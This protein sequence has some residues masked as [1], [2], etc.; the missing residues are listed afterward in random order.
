M[1]APLFFFRTASIGL[2][3][4]FF[5]KLCVAMFFKFLRL[6]DLSGILRNIIQRYFVD[7]CHFGQVTK[8]PDFEHLSGAWICCH[9]PQKCVVGLA[10]RS[11][12]IAKITHLCI[13]PIYRTHGF[14]FNPPHLRMLQ[15]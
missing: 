11:Y 13:L 6:F 1:C 10:G 5:A 2:S 7:S 15:H 8:L 9:M 3:L 12:I 14:E 4:H